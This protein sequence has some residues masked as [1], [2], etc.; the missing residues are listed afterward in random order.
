M[1]CSAGYV[2][3]PSKPSDAVRGEPRGIARANSYVCRA[4][5]YKEISPRVYIGAQVQAPAPVCVCACCVCTRVCV[6]V[7]AML[8]CVVRSGTGVNL[9]V[10][11]WHWWCQCDPDFDAAFT[12][13]QALK[14]WHAE[15]MLDFTDLL[16]C[17]CLISY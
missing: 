13:F 8:R 2:L 12:G 16:V 14:T 11:I 15:C 1:K 17:L 9:A 5:A 3:H 6:R 7:C 4:P 10:S